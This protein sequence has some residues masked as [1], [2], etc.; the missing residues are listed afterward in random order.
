MLRVVLVGEVLGF[1]VA[2]LMCGVIAV[3]FAA[4]RASRLIG[5][6]VSFFVSGELDCLVEVVMGYNAV[7]YRYAKRSK[8]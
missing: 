4:S 3:H 7:R 5:I 1:K 2:V 6:T 8:K